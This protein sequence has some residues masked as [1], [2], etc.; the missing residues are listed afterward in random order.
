M[1]KELLADFKEFLISYRE[2]W[3]SLDEA[4]IVCHSS[5]ALQVRWASH[6]EIVSDWDYNGSEVG[7]KQAYESYKGRNPKWYFEDILTEINKNKEAI[8]VFWVKFEIDGEI[9][10]NKLLF[11]E[12]FR[13]EEGVWKKIR[14]YVETS[15]SSSDAMAFF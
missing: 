11:V 9:F 5:N 10:E 13:K 15:F 2:A 14:E 7:W 4:Q 6:K 12:T 8:A 1:A 3:N